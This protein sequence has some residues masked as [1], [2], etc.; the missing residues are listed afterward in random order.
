[1]HGRLDALPFQLPMRRL[2]VSGLVF[3]LAVGL[4][5]LLIFGVLQT[6]DDSS[7]DQ[8]VAR[9]ERPVAHDAELDRLDGSGRG[10]LADY[11]GKVVVVNVFASWCAPCIKEAPVLERAQRT[12]A[13]RG[14]TVLGIAMHDARS[15]TQK[16]VED[17]GLTFPVL[18]DVDKAFA[19]GYGVNGLPETF[20]ID[21]VGRI[22]ALQRNQIDQKWVDRTLA[23]VLSRGP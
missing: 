5:G 20:V 6:S 11:R 12:L 4:V 8:A 9:G 3:A 14:G 21:R 18:R 2:V 13:R 22:V 7:I 1:M 15:D 23:R 19:D 10:S 17:H 16:F